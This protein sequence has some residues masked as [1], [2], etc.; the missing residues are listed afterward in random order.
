MARK[1]TCSVSTR[2]AAI[3][4]GR[5]MLTLAASTAI[6]LTGSASG[7]AE[8]VHH[9]AANGNA[10]DLVGSADGVA[11]GDVGYEEGPFGLAFHI[12]N[13]GAI[14]LPAPAGDFVNA[15]FTITLWCRCE[16][17]LPS[18]ILRKGDGCRGSEWYRLE[19]RP[20]GD[21]L[22]SGSDDETGPFSLL[23]RKADLFD[24][25]WHH[26]A[27]RRDGSL[28]SLWIDGCALVSRTMIEIGEL[29][30]SSPLTFGGP[31]CGTDGREGGP[32]DGGLDDIRWYAGALEDSEIRELARGPFGADLNG[33][34]R[35]DGADLALLL[36]AWGVCGVCCQEDLDGSGEVDGND[37]AKLLDQWSIPGVR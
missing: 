31:W 28:H 13:G 35:V 4:R 30:I 37:V 29:S 3:R 16:S 23:T 33:N 7:D 32:F 17:A 9:W 14:S 5:L 18:A 20:D 36:G 8:L 10:L 11:I 26:V 2:V 25:A 22:C 21:L 34:D 24:G 19:T 15:S 6:A 1:F 27:W 12:A